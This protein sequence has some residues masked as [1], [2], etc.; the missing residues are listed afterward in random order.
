MSDTVLVLCEADPTS[1]EAADL[2]SALDRDLSA[3]YPGLPIHGI[4]AANFREA[5]GVFL[6][7]RFAGIAVACGALRPMDTGAVEVKRMYVR[8]DHRGRGFGRAMLAALEQIAAG[9]GYR[10]IRLETGD[11]QREAIALY[12]RAGYQRIPCFGIHQQDAR[13]L[14]FE[15]AIANA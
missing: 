12:E 6:V 7:G 2:I 15:K 13:S 4:D 1:S 3:R 8:D 11:G 9:R 5:G 14:C 10:V